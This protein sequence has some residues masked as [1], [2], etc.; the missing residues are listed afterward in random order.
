MELSPSWESSSC[1][2]ALEFPN[3]LRKERV[4]VRVRR[5]LPLSQSWAKSI[6]STTPSHFL[7][8]NYILQSGWGVK[9]L[10]NLHL[11]QRPRMVQ[12]YF[13][14]L[15]QLHDMIFNLLIKHRDIATSYGLENRGT[16][17]PVPV[18]SNIFTSPYHPNRLWGPPNLLCNDNGGS[19][20][21]GD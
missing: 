6:Q 9:L 15:I 2:A 11:V 19:C 18:G 14:S 7:R 8:Y 4:H 5:C 17:V 1:T 3:I 13:H 20:P 16:G 10:T 12:L 21:P